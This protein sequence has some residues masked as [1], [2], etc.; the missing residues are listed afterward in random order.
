MHDNKLVEI[1]SDSQAALTAL[2][3]VQ[4]DFKVVL[5]CYK[6]LEKSED[7]H[8]MYYREASFGYIKAFARILMSMPK[9]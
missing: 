9:K 1:L 3:V 6:N 8:S 4:F 7:Y 2:Y 5:W